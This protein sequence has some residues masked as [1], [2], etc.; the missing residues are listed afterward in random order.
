M[1]GKSN[2]LSG[3]TH[4]FSKIYADEQRGAQYSKVPLGDT[5]LVHQNRFTALFNTTPHK[6]VN[7]TGNKVVVKSPE[8]V[9]YHRHKTQGKTYETNETKKE[10]YRQE[11]MLCE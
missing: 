9:C 1:Y 4:I 7:K 11:K 2:G 6:V 3:V 5:L 8:E 10:H